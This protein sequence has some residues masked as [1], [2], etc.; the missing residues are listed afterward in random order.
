VPTAGDGEDGS[1]VGAVALPAFLI[2]DDA[3]VAEAPARY[4]TAAE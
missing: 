1:E 4:L 3:D 2:E